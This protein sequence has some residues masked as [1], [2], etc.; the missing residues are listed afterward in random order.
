MNNPKITDI[1][2]TLSKSE[3]RQFGSFIR[4]PYFNNRSEVIRFYE[5]IKKFHPEF[6]FGKYNNEYFFSKVYPG[7]KF[8]SVLMRKVFSLTT[9]LL[10][11]FI[12][13]NSF[14]E[15]KFDFNIKMIFK[16]REKNLSKMFEKKSKQINVMLGSSI[17]DISYYENK[18]KYTS[19]LN[20][21][22]LNINE[23]SM[24]SKLQNELDDFMEYF[25][26]AI[27]VMYIQIG[28]AHV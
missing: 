28:R 15:D 17:Q 22:L 11:E 19:I 2:K 20:G 8:S 21:H 5:A 9:N 4:S 3:L 27:L 12:T 16:L 13:I 7:K 1:L 23:R 24:V 18:L 10:M 26:T 25:L 14:R 6:N